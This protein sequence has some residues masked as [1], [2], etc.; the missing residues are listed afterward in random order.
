MLH[1]FSFPVFKR[2]VFLLSI[3]CFVFFSFWFLF[4]LITSGPQS[5]ANGWQEELTRLQSEQADRVRQDPI[6]GTTP[7]DT[8]QQFLHLLREGDD[9][10]AS[11]YFVM[12]LQEP[13]RER[14]AALRAGDRLP[15][16]L[17]QIEDV[18]SL[19]GVFSSDGKR[20]FLE[21]PIAIDC[22]LTSSGLWKIEHL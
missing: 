10:G 13:W 6:G 5:H 17:L 3:V 8:L 7:S 11:Q 16:F 15:A 1:F 18:L 14:L 4:R 12:D 20:W 22:V 9:V 19:S 21:F 2:W